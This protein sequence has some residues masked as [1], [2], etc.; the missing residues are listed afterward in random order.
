[1]GE[2]RP[3]SSYRR[4]LRGG[5]RSEL[6]A[7]EESEGPAG[8]LAPLPGPQEQGG[9]RQLDPGSKVPV[10]DLTWFGQDPEFQHVCPSAIP[11]PP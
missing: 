10:G 1:M 5:W 11:N 8:E 2:N 7:G 6:G 4:I 9:W 3:F